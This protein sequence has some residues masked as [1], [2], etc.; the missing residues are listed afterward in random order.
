MYM[1]TSTYSKMTSLPKEI[2]ENAYVVN[3]S[4]GFASCSFWAEA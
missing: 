3:A 4:I 2:Y 1:Y